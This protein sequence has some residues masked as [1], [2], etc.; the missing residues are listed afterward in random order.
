LTVH[1]ASPLPPLPPSP[2]IA[3]STPSRLNPLQ[4][5]QVIDCIEGFLRVRSAA[6]G[7]L[8]LTQ[9]ENR[10]GQVLR[11]TRRDV[12]EKYLEVMAPRLQSEYGPTARTA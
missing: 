9:S 3:G 5:L 8:Q 7:P 1:L 6:V 11:E 10:P 2:S 12:I 4:L